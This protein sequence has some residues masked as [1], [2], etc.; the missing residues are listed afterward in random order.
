M[1][2]QILKTK[3]EDLEE[4]W[5]ETR[6]WKPGKNNR[7]GFYRYLQAVYK[8]YAQLRKTKGATKKARDKII[9]IYKL[10]TNK[11]SHPLN[12]IISGSCGE[13]KKTQSRWAQALR[14]AWKYRHKGKAKN[15]TM[16]KFLEL[17]GGAAGCAAKFA[18]KAKPSLKTPKK[19]SA[20]P[21]SLKHRP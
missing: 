16:M 7:I 3:I 17:N 10:S 15:I 4:I 13:N 8:F 20:V 14:Y 21:H 12:A 5:K 18:K 6:E 2:K 9:K 1:H 19:G 11:Q